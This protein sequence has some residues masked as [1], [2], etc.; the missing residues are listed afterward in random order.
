M[1]NDYSIKLIQALSDANGAP[2]F[3]DEVLDT[4]RRFVPSGVQIREDNIRNLYLHMPGNTGKKPM[5][6][7]D[8]HSDELGFIVQRILPNGQLK[9]LPLGGWIAFNAAAQKVRVKN[10]EGTYISGVITSKP[11]HFMHNWSRGEEARKAPDFADL[12]IDVGSGSYKETVEEFKI[13]V[14]APVVPDAWFEMLNGDIMMGKA[15]DCRAGCAAVIETMAGLMGLEDGLGVEVCGVLSSQEEIGIRGATVAK[16]AFNPP[17]RVSVVFEGTP[18][19]DTFLPENEQQC[20]VGKGPQVRHYDDYMI[21]HPRFLKFA[22]EIAK[23]HG[24]PFQDAVRESGGT[25]GWAYHTGGAGIPSIVIGVPTRYAHSH[26]GIAALSDYK[27]AVRWATL[28]IE[29]LTEEIID[30][31]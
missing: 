8:G 27:T 16:N 6:L 23:K 4:A 28:I 19:D 10:A 17:P 30:S 7:L 5:V 15:F 26:N 20:A 14:G 18:A 12:A 22:R 31:F 9:F 2:G 25:S 13:E 24:I 21:T 29:N 3:E 1:N 11:V